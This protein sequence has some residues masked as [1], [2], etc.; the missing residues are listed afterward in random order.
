MVVATLISLILLSMVFA[1]ICGPYILSGVPIERQKWQRELRQHRLQ[2][3]LRMGDFEHNISER[4]RQEKL[5][6]DSWQR[7]LEKHRLDEQLRMDNPELEMRGRQRQEKQRQENEC[8][9]EEQ[10][11]REEEE[12]Q[13]LG[14][15]WAEPEPN[16][17]CIGYNTRD[18][19]ARLLNTKPYNYNWLK[20]CE[21]IPITIHGSSIRTN[22]CEINQNVSPFTLLIE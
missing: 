14:L 6:Q 19:K 22:H 11:Q 4:K 13:R 18:Y 5:R 21:D 7:E 9:Q 1:V 17:H 8:L 20:P 10:W 16:E 15:Y 12:R 2:E 3:G